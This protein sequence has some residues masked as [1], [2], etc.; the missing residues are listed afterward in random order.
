MNTPNERQVGGTHYKTIYEHWDFT[1]DVLGGRYLEGC[2]TKYA[3]RW[4]KKGKPVQDLE[5]AQHFLDK[6]RAEFIRGRVHAPSLPSTVDALIHVQRFAEANQLWHAE[7]EVCRVLSQWTTIADLDY[8][9]KQLQRLIKEAGRDDEQER[10]FSEPSGDY[11]DQ[12]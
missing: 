8:V 6:L 1:T 4:R 9:A 3:T 11:V 12:D 7:S 2:I 10:Q 5:K